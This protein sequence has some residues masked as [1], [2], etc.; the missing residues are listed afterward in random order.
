MADSTTT[1]PRSEPRHDAPATELER[2][3]LAFRR[4][5]GLA[6]TDTVELTAFGGRQKIH[7]AYVRSPEAHLDL[8]A[9]AEAQ[10]ITGAYQCFNLIHEGLYARIGEGKWIPGA[11]RTSDNEVVELRAVYVDFDARRPRGISATDDEKARV[12]DVA[13]ACKEK[14]SRAF[15]TASLGLGDSGNGFSLFVALQPIAPSKDT[16]SRIQRFL[17]AIAQDF[18]ATGVEI[19]AS[20]CN[21]ARLCPAFGTLKRKGVDCA[22]RPWRRTSFRC[23]ESVSRV[24]LESL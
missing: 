16:V 9:Q 18:A 4:F 17:K 21:P 20:V 1:T 12:K 13:S 23:A 6:A 7:V 10:S 3:T 2:S 19:D 24:S 8:L 5:L 11:A 14:L 15:G 22:E